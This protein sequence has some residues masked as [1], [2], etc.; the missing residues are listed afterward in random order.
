MKPGK[1][2]GID[3]QKVSEALIKGVKQLIS[4]QPS[5]R[6]AHVHWTHFSS[7]LSSTSALRRSSAFNPFE[8][9][10]A[11]KGTMPVLRLFLF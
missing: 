1:T 7:S 10:L 2:S 6:K 9:I 3:Q 5:I 11:Y 8:Q 4:H